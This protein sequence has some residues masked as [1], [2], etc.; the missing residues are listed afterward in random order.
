MLTPANPSFEAAMLA[1][2]R[3]EVVQADHKAT[4][5]LTGLGIAGGALL[6]GVIAGDWKPG[7]YHAS[8]E[9]IWWIAVTTAAFAIIAAACA[10]WPRWSREDNNTPVFYW[11]HVARYKTVGDLAHALDNQSTTGDDRTRHQLHRLS[12]IVSLKYSLVRA[13]FVLVAI[14]TVLFVIAAIFG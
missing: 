7:N 9:A 1:E 3:A 6:G 13:S 10:V 12:R 11:G 4:F 2:A 14:A 8:G 5:V